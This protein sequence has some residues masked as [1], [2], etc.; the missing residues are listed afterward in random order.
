[1]NMSI[2]LTIS[3][4]MNLSNCVDNTKIINPQNCIK[5]LHVMITVF[6]P[7]QV[8]CSDMTPACVQMS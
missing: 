2:M 6:S 8:L 4:E 7:S 3:I 5:Y 1:M